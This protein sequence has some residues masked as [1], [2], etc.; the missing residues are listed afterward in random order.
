[1][2]LADALIP[3]KITFLGPGVRLSAQGWGHSSTCDTEKRLQRHLVPTLQHHPW[4]RGKW[5][6][7]GRTR[8]PPCVVPGV[9]A[10]M[11]SLSGVLVSSS[12][13]QILPHPMNRPGVMQT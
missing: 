13:P 10:E 1:M 8:G 4:K 12:V 9:I 7:W 5:Q 2:T 3:S 6:L 11:T